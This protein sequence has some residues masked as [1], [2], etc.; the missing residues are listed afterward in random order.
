M[1]MDY[2]TTLLSNFG[3]KLYR[4]YETFTEDSQ[5]LNLDVSIDKVC[6]IIG[7]KI[8]KAKI[9]KILNDLGFGVKDGNAG[10]LSVQVPLFRHDIKNVA[11]I[12]EEIVRIIG[13]DNIQ[14][15]PL[16][17][18]E[19]N[20][21]NKTSIDLVKKN[22]LRA[23]AVEN[24]FFETLTYVFTNKDTL[25]KYNLPTVKD[26]LDILNPIVKELDTYRTT[27][28]MN[29]I[30]A[31]SNN[32]K[33]GFKRV[34]FFEIGTIFNENREESKK[35]SFIFSGDVEFENFLN[36]GKPRVIDFF[37]F[38]KKVLN[39]IGS[40]ELETMEKINN[41]L[42]H[43]Y[44]NAKVL[45]NGKDAGFISKLHPNVANDYDLPDTFIAEIDFESITNDL[46]KANE[47]SKFQASKRDLS[48]V[49]PKDMEYSRIKA[50]INSL[51]DEKIKEFN[52]VD[53]YSDEK[54]G[55]NESLTIRFVLQS[56][57]KTLEEEDITSTMDK[58][59]DTLDKKLNIGMR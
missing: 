50:A 24:S 3:A 16:C 59:L 41:D 30:E 48:L 32:F 12:T 51:N 57:D 34:A 29:L 13:I 36:G 10:V 14:S 33:Q 52:L 46:V 55:D 4:G 2:F 40:F 19:A 17:T 18:E 5:E 11:D 49:V 58:I 25:K 53:I 9:E 37:D 47:Y 35:I 23:K 54:L 42:I 43:P 45:I 21:V 7:E 28:L 8:E 27:I 20:R 39:T 26:E 56:F 38:S 1:G 6:S 31:V 44:Q 22:R 15:K